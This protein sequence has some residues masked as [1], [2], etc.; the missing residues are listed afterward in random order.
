[1]VAGI[2]LLQCS[3]QIHN[4]VSQRL[5]TCRTIWVVRLVP[6][7]TTAKD[8]CGMDCS[9]AM[10][11][12]HELALA[13]IK[14]L[15]FRLRITASTDAV[16][17]LCG[18]EVLLKLKSLRDIIVVLELDIYAILVIEEMSDLENVPLVT[19]LVIR[20]LSHIPRSVR[21]L[22]WQ[23]NYRSSRPEPVFYE[24]LKQLATKYKSVRGSAYTSQQT[25][26]T[27]GDISKSLHLEMTT[28]RT[29]HDSHNRL[30]MMKHQTT[31][32]QMKRPTLMIPECR[33]CCRSRT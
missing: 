2:R 5:T 6:P 11:G 21:S 17:S 13:K 15:H 19:G 1:M 12:L 28:I 26:R 31:N 3:R 4:E 14:A 29:D 30:R 16:F 25:T 7:S 18:L 24:F 23:I 10:S 9:L 20:L 8:S 22:G 33:H 27:Q 32:A